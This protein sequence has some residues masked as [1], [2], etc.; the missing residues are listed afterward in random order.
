[1]KWVRSMKAAILPHA[2]G[3]YVNYIDPELLGWSDMYYKTNYIRLF[4]TKHAVDPHNLFRFH[5]S[6]GAHEILPPPSPEPDS[7]WSRW[8]I[9]VVAAVPGACAL[10]MCGV[11]CK[12]KKNKKKNR[13]LNKRLLSPSPGGSESTS[14][15]PSHNAPAANTGSIMV[16]APHSKK[17]SKAK[18]EQK[19]RSRKK[20]RH[21]S[22]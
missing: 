5:Q 10:I 9:Y 2:S 8:W 3:S 13:D 16:A 1:M 6:I 11:C 12:T 19:T 21:T 18:K 7:V 4:A 17:R 15:R 22:N 20:E 14:A